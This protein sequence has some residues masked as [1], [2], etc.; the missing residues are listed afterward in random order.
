LWKTSVK[1]ALESAFLRGFWRD[2]FLFAYIEQKIDFLGFLRGIIYTEIERN[3]E[4]RFCRK[5]LSKSWGNYLKK[6]LQAF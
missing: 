3:T 2:I 1:E 5:C 4:A 6:S